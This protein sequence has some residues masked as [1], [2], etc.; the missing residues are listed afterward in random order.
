MIDN[1]ASFVLTVSRLETDE[2]SSLSESEG[3]S[4]PS[5]SWANWAPINEFGCTNDD[6]DGTGIIVGPGVTLAVVLQAG[7]RDLE[8]LLRAVSLDL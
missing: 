1:L 2:I 7:V 8:R 4:S 3:D 6:A 5:S